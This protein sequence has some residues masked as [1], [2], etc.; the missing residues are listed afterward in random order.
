MKKLKLYLTA[1]ILGA[2]FLMNSYAAKNSPINLFIDK[3]E[4]NHSDSEFFDISKEY[5]FITIK[6]SH[7]TAWS[8]LPKSNK[9]RKNIHSEV[10]YKFCK[11]QKD[12]WVDV[13]SQSD[14][15]I[16][17]FFDYELAKKFSVSKERI[18]F[19]K[20][21]GIEI[22][23]GIITNGEF[24]FEQNIKIWISPKHK[25]YFLVYRRDYL[26]LI[27]H[28]VSKDN[29]SKRNENFEKIYKK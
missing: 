27:D 15:C 16:D 17:R 8:Y 20:E 29:G 28:I 23:I 14:K 18:Y 2:T 12:L 19:K 1:V 24:N 4:L 3:T 10:T 21:N 13:D 7:F 6:R 22:E 11:I 25:L 9:Q 5:P 26:D